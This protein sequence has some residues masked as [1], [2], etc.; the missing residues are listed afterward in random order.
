MKKEE[1]IWAKP[2]SRLEIHQLHS[3]SVFP[4][5]LDRLGDERKLCGKTI[6]RLRSSLVDKA[7]DAG[8]SEG[9][10]I[11]EI[12]DIAFLDFRDQSG[13]LMPAFQQAVNLTR[14]DP[15][16]ELEPES[17]DPATSLISIGGALLWRADQSVGFINY[18]VYEANSSL[19][20]FEL[21][22]LYIAP[23]FRC[24]GIGEAVAEMF[25]AYA[26]HDGGAFGCVETLPSREAQRFW[27]RFL[28]RQLDVEPISPGQYQF[29]L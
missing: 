25:F 15:D 16:G 6:G 17:P 9:P 29:K 21:F 1:D 2:L 4:G 12:M 10:C 23:D 7:N 26:K 8:Q 14:A 13:A 27:Q 3:T 20:C 5:L 19:A 18:R 24:Q 11:S 22:K 28:A